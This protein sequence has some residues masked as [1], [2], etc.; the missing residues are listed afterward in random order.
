VS[1]PPAGVPAGKLELYEK[2]VETL[3]GVPHRGAVGGQ[4]NEEQAAGA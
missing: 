3:P 1:K 2:L 4:V